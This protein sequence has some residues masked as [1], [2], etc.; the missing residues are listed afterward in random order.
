MLRLSKRNALSIRKIQL[1]DWEE[2]AMRSKLLCAVAIALVSTVLAAQE[3][4]VLAAQGKYPTHPITLIVGYAAGGSGEVVARMLSEFAREKRGGVVTV[5]FKPGAGATIAADQLAR[6][7]ADGYTLSTFSGNPL[8]AAPHLQK[9]NYDPLKDFT[10]V[11]T[12]FAISNAAFV[13]TDSPFKSFADVV[14]YARANPGKLRWTTSAPRGTSHLA[15]EAA[16]RKEGVQTT[17]VPFKG[18]SEDLTALLG[19]HIEMSV[20]SNYGTYL[21]AGEVR[22]LAET[23]SVKV[24]GMPNVPTFQELGFP[25]SITTTYGLFGPAG[26]PDEVV[27]WWDGLIKEMMKAPEY[28]AIAKTLHLTPYYEDKATFTRAV[29]DGYRKFG[30]AVKAQGLNK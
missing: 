27:A 10:Y 9:V 18:G 15:T 21:E 28:E 5:E 14:A 11:A 25:I 13:R 4:T 17:F 7:K 22:L 29:A 26:L 24:P 2:Q 19:K 16:F 20:S 1:Y 3:S 6:A 8:L 30:D 12:F 23:G